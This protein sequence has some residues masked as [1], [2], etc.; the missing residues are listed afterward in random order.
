M[1]L[2]G[3]AAIFEATWT[4]CYPQLLASYFC[5]FTVH[6]EY[7]EWHLPQLNLYRGRGTVS[8]INRTTESSEMSISSAKVRLEHHQQSKQ[9]NQS[10]P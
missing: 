6:D 7:I 3:V 4:T 8:E 5:S 1:L 10:I 9:S 2:V